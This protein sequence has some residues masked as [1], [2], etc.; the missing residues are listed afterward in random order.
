MVCPFALSAAGSNYQS[1]LDSSI[2]KLKNM[3]AD[4]MVSESFYY[5]MTDSIFPDWMGTKWD[6]NGVSNVP[7]KGSIACGYFVSTTLK[8]IGFNLNRYELA[9]QAA[10]TVIDI[11]CGDKK[12]KSVLEADIIHKIKIKG[13][14]RLYVVGLDYHV[15]FLA[16]ENDLVYFIH[17]DYLSG[18]VVCEKASESISFSSTNGYVYGELTN[19]NSL[20]TKWKNG[21]KIY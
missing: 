14:K 16:V 1:K 2:K 7:G 6:Y 15:G 10:Y 12:M 11:L 20:F 3:D 9:Q 17:S 18:K 19:N 13:N 4:S 5:I 8:H 21:T